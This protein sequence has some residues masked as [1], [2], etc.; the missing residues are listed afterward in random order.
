MTEP[1]SPLW[2]RRWAGPAVVAATFLALLIWTWQKWLDV[3][4][5]FGVQL[6]VPWQL[7]QGKVLYRDIAHY[8]GPLSVYYNAL[9]FRIFGVNLRVL[10]FANFPVLIAIVIVIYH[11][12]GKLGGKLCATVSAISFLILFA[13]AHLTIAGNYNFVCPYEYDYTHATLLGLVCLIFLNRAITLRRAIDPAIAG[14]LA[15]M[16]FLTRSEFFVAII[17]AAVAAAVILILADKR[18]L[19]RAVLAF[20][21]AAILP[22][23]ISISLLRLAMPWNIAIHGT[24]GM[25]PALF[26]GNVSAQ[27][28]YHHSMGI[29]DLARSLRLMAAWTVAWC[30]PIAAFASWAMLKTNR[31]FKAAIPIAFLVGA[32]LAGV[33]WRDRDWLSL[34]RPLPLAVAAVWVVAAVRILRRR[35]LSSST[36]TPGEDR[37]GGSVE[38]AS[39]VP[40]APLAALL[41]TFS[42]LL[43][44]KVFF[45]ARI[46]HYGC[47]LAMPAVMLIVI[48]FFGWIP[49]DLQRLG[50]NPAIFLSGIAGVWAVVLLVHLAITATAMKSLTIPVGKGPDQFYADPERGY[51]V[52]SALLVAE[53][54]PEGKTLACFP[55]GIMINYLARRPTATRFVNFNPPDLL[56]FGEDS[57]LRAIEA[58]PPDFIFIVHKDTSEFGEKFFGHDYGQQ[59]YAWIDAHYHLQDLPMVNLGAEPLRSQ[60]FGIRLLIPRPPDN[61]QQRLILQPLSPSPGTPGEGWG[62]VFR[63]FQGACGRPLTSRRP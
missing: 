29:D 63:I 47:W 39:S 50:G 11:L 45:Y 21:L 3:L 49:N 57:I 61:G 43:L 56:L 62:G 41:A 42:L 22:P 30:I 58:S 31:T 19:V 1:A 15:G 14:F 24:L 8:T 54:M 10:E 38:R 20:V 55:E 9:A 34:F 46:E 26:R 25:W 7:T 5:D 51:C 52:T 4:V 37:G 2:Q 36:G 35:N 18:T 53:Q 32:I 59:L 33:Q 48:A 40:T 13:F 12:A 23:L 17:G 6:Y 60:R 44:A 16:I 28:F 27:Q